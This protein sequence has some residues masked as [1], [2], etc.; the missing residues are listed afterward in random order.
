MHNVLDI[1]L[2]GAATC[3]IDST[4]A[5][6]AVQTVARRQPVCRLMR[7]VR[8]ALEQ[9]QLLLLLVVRLRVLV[10][11]AL[12]QQVPLW[13]PFHRISTLFRS[14][15]VNQDRAATVCIVI[16]LVAASRIRF[17]TLLIGCRIVSS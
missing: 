10:I 2:V 4:L 3:A 14:I 11:L 17:A 7:S 5:D 13:K 6:C 1:M 12:A 8:L 16:L 15:V 9:E